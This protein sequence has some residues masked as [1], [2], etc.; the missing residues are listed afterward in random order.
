M[1]IMRFLILYPRFDLLWR[2]S[3][4]V[5]FSFFWHLSTF[6]I[7]NLQTCIVLLWSYNL[8]RFCCLC[9]WEQRSECK[10]AQPP[11]GQISTAMLVW[12]QILNSNKLCNCGV[13]THTTPSN[14]STPH[15]FGLNLTQDQCQNNV[16]LTANKHHHTT[17]SGGDLPIPVQPSFFKHLSIHE[18]HL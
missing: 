4:T 7:Q 10:L 5:P 12:I 13:W 8:Q 11:R 1:I 15:A 2:D 18:P 9:H 3:F 6:A 14:C 17:R 16:F